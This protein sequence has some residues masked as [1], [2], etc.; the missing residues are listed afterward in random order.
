MTGESLRFIDIHLA[1]FLAARSGF[2]GEEQKRFQGLLELLSSSLE[3]GHSCLKLKEDELLFVQ[4]SGLVSEGKN[5]PLVVHG[6]R[7]YLHRYYSYEAKL[8]GNLTILAAEHHHYPQLDSLLDDF[9]GHDSIEKD[10]QKEAARLAL[11][12]SLCL[13]SGGPGTGKTTTVV[14][15]LAVMLELLGSQTKIGLAAP[16]GKAA[17]RLQASI[18]ASLPYLP[19]EGDVAKDI[20]A[21]AQTLHRL[22]G[23]IRKSSRFRHNADNPLPIDVLV[24]DE[25]SMVDLALMSKVVDALKPGARLILLG[26]KDQLASVESGAVLADCIRG[27]PGNTVE[28]RKSYR[29]DSGIATV[30]AAI[31]RSDGRRCCDLLRGDQF[32]NV[33]FLRESLNDFAGSRYRVYMDC[34][35]SYPE[36][37]LDHIFQAF[38][39]FQ[40]LCGT[41]HG[42][43]GMTGVNNG[44]E[45]YLKRNGY[46]CQPGEWYPGRP[47]MITKNDYSFGLFNGD[48]GICLPDPEDGTLKVW[49][50]LGSETYRHC[51]TYRLPASE[52][53]FAMTIHKSQGSEF[54]DVLIALPE[55]DNRVLNKQLVYT[56]V[57]RAKERVWLLAEEQVVIDTLS[58]DYL[59]SSGLVEMLKE[60]SC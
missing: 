13:I 31:N 7:L 54:Q 3:S 28:L 27:L 53:V 20:P 33:G 15:I 34:V 8:A 39:E 57:T 32:S 35:R 51:P 44:V 21:D 42:V 19:Q 60:K 29:F 41:R 45:A 47:V 36:T 52:T 26:D 49:F 14:R 38:D 4:T 48:I 1:R 10:Y 5:T 30:A 9:F 16:T 46:P 56:A 2:A 11:Q 43:R 40:I 50:D 37:T 24:I 23:V 58:R 17:K 18:I 12:R 25:A 22:L 55:N 59:R 6:N